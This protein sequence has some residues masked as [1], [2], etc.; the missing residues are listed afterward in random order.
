MN[1]SQRLHELRSAPKK[2][3]AVEASSSRSITS[4]TSNTLRVRALS[5]VFMEHRCR[6]EK[7]AAKILGSPHS[8]EDVVQDAYIKAAETAATTEIERPASYL[9]QIVRNLA[10]DHYRRTI[11]ESRYFTSEEEG[12]EIVDSTG[13]PE[14]IVIERL[15]LRSLAAALAD[16]PKR[17]QRAF[18]LHSIDGYTQREVAKQLNV[19]PTLVNFMIRDALKHCREA[20][21]QKECGSCSD[22]SADR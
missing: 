3:R 14:T 9:Y 18:E 16:L 2:D 4:I 21:A 11:L 5:V 7:H 13:T 10:I 17:T 20:T 22:R 6:L 8:A 12:S 1:A 15:Q 19:S